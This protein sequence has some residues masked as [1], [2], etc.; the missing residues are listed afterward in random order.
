MPEATRRT[1]MKNFFLA[2]LVGKRK[3]SIES[4]SHVAKKKFFQDWRSEPQAPQQDW[5]AHEQA[6]IRFALASMFCRYSAFEFPCGGALHRQACRDQSGRVKLL[7]RFD[8]E[9]LE[10]LLFFLCQEDGAQENARGDA[11][12]AALLQSIMY[13]VYLQQFLLGGPCRSTVQG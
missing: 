4:A 9:L 1:R 5:Q 6:D 12:E 10:G 2:V 11:A 3:L 7:V 8:S 13:V